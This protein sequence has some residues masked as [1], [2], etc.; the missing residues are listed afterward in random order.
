MGLL[1]AALCNTFLVFYLVLDLRRGEAG[2]R[3]PRLPWLGFIA[4]TAGLFCYL[5]FAGAG[6]NVSPAY[7]LAAGLAAAT[8]LLLLK[9]QRLGREA[10]SH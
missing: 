7:M 4:A 2:S 5:L 8:T 3:P 1:P 6:L 9:E 10:P